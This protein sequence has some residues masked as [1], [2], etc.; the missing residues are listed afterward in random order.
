[1]C[2]LR[3]MAPSANLTQSPVVS[4]LEKFLTELKFREQDMS[5]ARVAAVP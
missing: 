4:L 5:C 1:M 3:S 2:A